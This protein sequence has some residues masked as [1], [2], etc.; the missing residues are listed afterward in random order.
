VFEDDTCCFP[1]NSTKYLVQYFGGFA[2]GLLVS[3]SVAV[4]AREN[5]CALGTIEKHSIQNELI[6]GSSEK[7]D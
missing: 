2:A 5:S 6:E 3:P 7:L 4:T 1:E